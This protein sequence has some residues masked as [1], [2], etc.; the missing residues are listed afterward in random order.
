MY[1]E[2]LTFKGYRVVIA[3]SGA[4]GIEKA[5]SERPSLIFMDLRMPQMSGTEA[6]QLLRA[7]NVFTD[8]PII[9][10]TA[11]AMDDERRSAL[12]SGFDE[13]IPKPCNPDD[14]IAAVERLL[15]PGA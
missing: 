3:S 13:V 6:M 11:Q 14:L 12:A 15:S 4:E 10:F 9:A 5:R 1:Q 7:D 8:V 2:Y